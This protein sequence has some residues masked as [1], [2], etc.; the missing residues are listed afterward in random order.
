LVQAADLHD[1]ISKLGEGMKGTMADFQI[2]S[3][4]ETGIMD[5]FLYKNDKPEI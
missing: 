5:V 1:A 4:I 3:V 2:A